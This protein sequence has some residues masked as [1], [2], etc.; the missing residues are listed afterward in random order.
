MITKRKLQVSLGI[1]GAILFVTLTALILGATLSREVNAQGS[2]KCSLRTIQGTYI[3]EARGFIKD[4]E[5]TL[6]WAEAGVWT[7]DGAGKAVGFFS[8]SVDGA[9]IAR[10]KPLTATYELTTGCVFRAVD[11]ESIVFDLYPTEQGT[12]MTYFS[13]GVSGTMFKR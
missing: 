7:L 6:P 8:A 1:S 2:N 9:P 12:M 3:F 10:Q 4:G 13:A 11:S 5:K